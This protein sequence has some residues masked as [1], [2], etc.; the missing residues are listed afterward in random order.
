[1][2]ARNSAN[3]IC[4]KIHDFVQT[5]GLHFAI[6]QTPY[7]SYIT[8]RR[9]FIAGEPPLNEYLEEDAWKI[10]LEELQKHIKQLENEKKYLEVICVN[11]D[12]EMSFVKGEHDKIIR[13]LHAFVDNLEVMKEGLKQDILKLN[14]ELGESKLEH[15]KTGKLLKNSQKENHNLSK[16]LDNLQDNVKNLRAEKNELKNAKTKAESD[17]R[18]LEKKVTKKVTRRCQ[19]L[20]G[21]Q[22]PTE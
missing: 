21:Y 6:N 5:S 7:S 17:F 9:K 12:E 4:N 1:M 11:K 22:R 16:T 8:I 15:S 2:A 18:K 13:N 20:K 3:S 10:K 14:N 19:E